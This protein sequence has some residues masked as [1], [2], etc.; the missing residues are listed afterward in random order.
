MAC[1]PSLG[2]LSQSDTNAA[3]TRPSTSVGQLPRAVD[4][5][6]FQIF[7]AARLGQDWYGELSSP[8]EAN[9]ELTSKGQ[10]TLY[11]GGISP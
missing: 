9:F 4:S 10:R 3:A 6:G 8:N 5:A 11:A 2:S 7:G 1:L